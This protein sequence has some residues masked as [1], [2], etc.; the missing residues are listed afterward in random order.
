MMKIIKLI[1]KINNNNNK[2]ILKTKIYLYNSIVKMKKLIK[3]K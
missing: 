3:I 2:Y 1:L